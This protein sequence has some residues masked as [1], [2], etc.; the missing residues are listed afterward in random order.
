MKVVS[1]FS[2]FTFI[3][4]IAFLLFV[5]FSWQQPKQ[6]VKSASGTVLHVPFAKEL[7]ITLGFT[8]IIINMIMNIVYL[9]V[10]SSGRLKALPRWL[11][12]TNFLFLLLQFCYFFLFNNR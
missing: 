5:F 1:F 2:R 4:N 8:A 10:L 7:I 12:I 6:P 9:F 11:I 3:C